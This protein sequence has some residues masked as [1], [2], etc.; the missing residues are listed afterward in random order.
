MR[1]FCDYVFSHDD[2]WGN[3]QKQR[4]ASRRRF[5]VSTHSQ[6]ARYVLMNEALVVFEVTQL[7]YRVHIQNINNL[8]EIH[9]L[10]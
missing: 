9:L 7:E 2:L 5:D 3:Y 4:D 8:T 1:I 10:G 6:L